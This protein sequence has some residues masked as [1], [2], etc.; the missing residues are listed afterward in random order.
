MNLA[1][2]AGS[3]RVTEDVMY[4]SDTRRPLDVHSM[5]ACGHVCRGS[6]ARITNRYPAC[7]FPTLA[8]SLTAVR[9][10]P[11]DSH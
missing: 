2:S 3:Q 9:V 5:I 10:K 4:D 8:D 7:A 6:K 11:Y 1:A